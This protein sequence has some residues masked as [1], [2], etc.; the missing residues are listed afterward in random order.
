MK[1]STREEAQTPLGERGDES[2]RISP[3]EELIS[4]ISCANEL[5]PDVNRY[6]LDLVV[7]ELEHGEL[8]PELAKWF[9]NRLKL[10]VAGDVRFESAFYLGKRKGGQRGTGPRGV[11][12]EFVALGEAILRVTHPEL[13]RNS[14]YVMLGEPLHVSADRIKDVLDRCKKNR[15]FFKAA[16][17]DDLRSFEGFTFWTEPDRFV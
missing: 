3:H 17:L 9:A 10:V 14:V 11:S 2:L 8:R 13:S 12:D 5:N 6:L 1:K 15:I 16:S 4:A 7:S